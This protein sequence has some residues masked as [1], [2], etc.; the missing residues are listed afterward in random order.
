MPT[1]ALEDVKISLR[2]GKPVAA[3][4]LLQKNAPNSLITA[5]PIYASLPDGTLRF[6]ARVFADGDETTFCLQTA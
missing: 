2:T 5:V 3:G 6:L 1:Y 4:T